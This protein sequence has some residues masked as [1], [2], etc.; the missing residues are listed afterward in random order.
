MELASMN[1]IASFASEDEALALVRAS[2]AEHGT[3]YVPT[4]ALGRIDRRGQPLTGSSLVE[5]ALE[6]ART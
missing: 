6:A 3:N 5:R 2:I 4:W 1:V